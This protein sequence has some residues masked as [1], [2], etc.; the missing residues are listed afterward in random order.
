MPKGKY[1]HGL[2]L[3]VSKVLGKLGDI[4]DALQILFG[5]LTSAISPDKETLKRYVSILGS[6]NQIRRLLIPF[7]S[8][9]PSPESRVLKGHKKFDSLVKTYRKL[10][11]SNSTKKGKKK[12]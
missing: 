5:D 6:L 7:V 2:P 12:N 9:T 8:E 1:P 4:D 3:D 11:K 10:K